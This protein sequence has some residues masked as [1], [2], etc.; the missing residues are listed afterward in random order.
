VRVTIA[1]REV[2]MTLRDS[3][4]DRLIAR[5]TAVIERY[6]VPEASSQPQG[7]NWCNIHK[8]PMR[9]NHKDG[10]TWFSHKVDG[11]FCKGR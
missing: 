9:E 11:Q 2:Q 6:P 10:K 4:E 1:G 5:L 7:K 3:S 8:V